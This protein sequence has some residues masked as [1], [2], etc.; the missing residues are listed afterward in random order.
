MEIREEEYVLLS[1][2][3][4]FLFCPRQCAL[5]YIEMQWKDNYLTAKGNILHEKAHADVTEKRKDLY[6]V[7]GLRLV[8]KNH[9]ISGMADVVEFN[10]ADGEIE[11]KTCR[12]KGKDGFWIPVPVEYKKGKAHASDANN[13]Q[14]CAQAF[15]LEEMLDVSIS[16][17]VI[18]HGDEKRRETVILD[19]AL[20]ELTIETINNTR[21]LIESGRT[22]LAEYDNRC[23]SCSLYD[24]CMPEVSGRKSRGYV[25]S[26]FEADDEKTS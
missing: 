21:A 8:S 12:L 4:H 26:I 18:Y 2:L 7:H 10:Q 16:E 19:D 11:G 15:C 9:A 24:I 20:R 22:P 14:L 5:A 17:G 3:Q 13:V 6:S 25:N 1:A 23:R